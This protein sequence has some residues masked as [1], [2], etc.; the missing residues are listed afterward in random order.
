MIPALPDTLDLVDNDI[1]H[2]R[3]FRKVLSGSLEALGSPHHP[4][5]VIAMNSSAAGH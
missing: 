5:D 4:P 1:N 3:Y 2:F